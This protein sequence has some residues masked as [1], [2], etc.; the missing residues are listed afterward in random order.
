VG[1]GPREQLVNL[2]LVNF[3]VLLESHDY[4]HISSAGI[5]LTKL[6]VASTNWHI[7]LAMFGVV[8]M[9]AAASGPELHKS[10]RC[11]TNLGWLSPPRC[12]NCVVHAS[13]GVDDKT[14]FCYLLPKQSRFPSCHQHLSLQS[15]LVNRTY[16]QRLG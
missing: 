14:I 8:N 2:S 11:L 6:T 12:I 10:V 1:D 9:Y 5:W 16:P 13:D 15:Y 4:L 7:Y 3:V